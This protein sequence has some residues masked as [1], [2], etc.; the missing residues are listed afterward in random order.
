MPLSS[1][2]EPSGSVSQDRLIHRRRCH[3]Q[4]E[5]RRGHMEKSD[6]DLDPSIREYCAANRPRRRRSHRRHYWATTTRVACT[7]LA[8][9]TSCSPQACKASECLPLISVEFRNLPLSATY[10]LSVQVC[11]AKDCQVLSSSDPGLTVSLNGPTGDNGSPFRITATATDASGKVVLAAE[12][13]AM[14]RQSAHSGT[15]ENC[16]TATLVLHSGST[17][18][19]QIAT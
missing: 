12:G 9:V 18:L 6:R 7:I 16:K 1:L 14:M 2:S 3:R 10:P 8:A 13:T 5:P 4:A 17:A 19:E 15:C 11:V